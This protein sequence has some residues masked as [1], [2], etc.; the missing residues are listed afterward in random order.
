[1]E[2]ERYKDIYQQIETNIYIHTYICVSVCIY[3][4]VYKLRRQPERRIQWP[5]DR[6]I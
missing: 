1:M 3:I 6:K 4:H 5:K 2:R